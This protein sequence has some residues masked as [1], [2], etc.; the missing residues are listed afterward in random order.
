MSILRLHRVS[1]WTVIATSAFASIGLASIA[2]VTPAVAQ[3]AARLAIFM[4][5]KMIAHPEF[6]I[7][8]VVQLQDGAGRPAHPTSRLTV[9]LS[10]S[11]PGTLRIYGDSKL[12][13]NPPYGTFKGDT[14]VLGHVAAARVDAQG[15]AVIT[16]SAP[17]LGSVSASMGEMVGTPHGNANWLAAHSVAVMLLPPVVVAGD[18]GP[19][20]FYQVLDL[21]G[22]P[23]ADPRNSGAGNATFRLESSNP[24]VFPTGPQS[25][26]A[27]YFYGGT[28]TTDT[29]HPAA[30]GQATLSVHLLDRPQLG[31]GHATL[32]V[33]P[34]A[35]AAKIDGVTPNTNTNTT[36]NPPPNTNVTNDKTNT[37]V[38]P[39]PAEIVLRPGQVWEGDLPVSAILDLQARL[40]YEKLAG[41]S[42]ALDVMINGQRVAG[43]LLNKAAQYTYKDGRTFSY[44]NPTQPGWMVFFTPD[45]SGNNDDPNSGYRVMTNPG[46]AYHYRWNI[47]ALAGK[48]PTMHVRLANTIASTSSSLV[49]RLTR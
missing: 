44:Y 49:I 35:A 22:R 6:T 20:A 21:N 23:T 12:T 15:G 16:A 10:S 17:G 29:M 46:E 36:S 8:V 11:A 32:T 43:P 5:N 25:S 7:P 47:A 13:F 30:A 37:A 27:D 39:V 38:T 34:A 28:R 19:V 2:L 24:A 42:F 41:S 9:T 3:E 1:S 40:Q 48:G 45:F 26:L 31:G 18:R 33:V 14:Y 4:P